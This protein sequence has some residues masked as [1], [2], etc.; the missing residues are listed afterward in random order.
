MAY[1]S[2]RT[3]VAGDWSGDEDLIDKLYEWNDRDDLLLSFSDAHSLTQSRDTSLPCSIKKSLSIRLDAS[4]TFLL[5]VGNETTTV[6]KGSC[7]Y[8]DSYSSYWNRCN[9][10]NSIDTRSFI[11]FEC[12]KAVRNN[13][14]IIVIYNYSSVI[15]SKCPYILRDKGDHIN[16]YY[17][18]EDGK[19]Y[20]NYAGIKNA[21]LKY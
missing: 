19:R 14:N 6:T 1:Y 9:R 10:G 20:W 8:C 5:V 11:Q 12:E 2:T 16:G 7:Q 3:Y 13:L 18:G 21:I 4:K 15:K 17:Y